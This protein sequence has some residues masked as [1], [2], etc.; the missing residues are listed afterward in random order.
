MPQCLKAGVGSERND[1]MNIEHIQLLRGTA[2]ALAS[3]NPVLLAGELGLE[4]DTGKFKFGYG[5]SNWNSLSYAG[6]GSAELPSEG[7]YVIKDGAYVPAT[8]VDMTAE[9]QPS[10]DT[11]EVVVAVDKDMQAYQLTGINVEVNS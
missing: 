2:E 5:T 3:V 8:V 11:E 4:T 7:V 1:N 6:G 10:I 9:W